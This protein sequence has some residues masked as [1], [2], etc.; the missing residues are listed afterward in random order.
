MGLGFLKNLGC[1]NFLSS[2]SHFLPKHSVYFN[3]YIYLV[4]KE[5]LLMF[6]TQEI[7]FTDAVIETWKRTLGSPLRLLLVNGRSRRLKTL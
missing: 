2:T 1:Y 4:V 7:I 3:F 6:Q 5:W